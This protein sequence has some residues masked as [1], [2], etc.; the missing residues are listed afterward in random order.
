MGETSQPDWQ[1]E[2]KIKKSKNRTDDQVGLSSYRTLLFVLVRGLH[3]LTKPCSSLQLGRHGEEAGWNPLF[4][5]VDELSII[6]SMTQQEHLGLAWHDFSRSQKVRGEQDHSLYVTGCSHLLTFHRW[7]RNVPKQLLFS[8]LP[9]A[10][11]SLSP[12]P[13]LLPPFYTGGSTVSAVQPR[14]LRNS[15]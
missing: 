1:Q 7:N 2:R 13:T 8:L 5:G 6:P 11:C 10:K 15:S 3:C 4:L 9:I 14:Q 12:L